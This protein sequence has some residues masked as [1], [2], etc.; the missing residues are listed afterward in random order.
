M[1][2]IPVTNRL[3]GN[4]QIPT[5]NARELHAFLQVK[6]KF[7]EWINRRINEYKFIENQD[8]ISFSENSEKLQNGRP[9]KD[10]FISLNMAKELAMVERTDKGRQ[11]RQYFID[12]ERQLHELTI[13]HQ[14]KAVSKN[15]NWHLTQ[16]IN[17]LKT[18]V[19]NQQK[20]MDKIVSL[21]EQSLQLQAL[22]LELLQRQALAKK[23]YRQA[24]LYDVD[25]VFDLVE[26][27]YTNAQISE[28]L[29][30][31]TYAIS[32]IKNHRY[33]LDNDTGRLSYH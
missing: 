19:H 22:S 12:C 16:L 17:T 4:R 10:Y 18:T 3:I 1:E 32:R 5:A 24:V 11:A 8:F 21:H 26:Q 29:G 31:S 2:L 20:A 25:C 27:G 9:T 30:L 13:A 15:A 23:S 28:K 6:S 7:A 14:T 33:S